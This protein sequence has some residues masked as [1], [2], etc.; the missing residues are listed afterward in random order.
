[1]HKQTKTHTNNCRRE[2]Q[3]HDNAAG[4]DGTLISSSLA[5]DPGPNLGFFPSLIPFTLGLLVS[6]A[7]IISLPRRLHLLLP[8]CHPPLM[9]PFVFYKQDRTQVS[10]NVWQAQTLIGSPLSSTTN[11]LAKIKT[12]AVKSWLLP[13]RVSWP[14]F[15][16]VKQPFSDRWKAQVDPLQHSAPS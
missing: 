2:G 5:T 16:T 1:M 6:D 3:S 11:C 13:D 4:N 7:S 10:Q 15:P 14:H 8:P 12:P 9:C